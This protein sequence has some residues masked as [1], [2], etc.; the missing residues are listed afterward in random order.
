MLDDKHIETRAR[1]LPYPSK[2]DMRVLSRT[3]HFSPIDCA[4]K[5]Y[6]KQYTV[7]RDSEFVPLAASTYPAFLYGD[8]VITA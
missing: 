7:Q 4:Q 8:V 1:G 6:K 3:W 5:T 2:L